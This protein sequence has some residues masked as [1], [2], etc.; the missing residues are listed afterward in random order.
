M[1]AMNGQE[2]AGWENNNQIIKQEV[3]MGDFVFI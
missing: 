1:K 3:G 2:M